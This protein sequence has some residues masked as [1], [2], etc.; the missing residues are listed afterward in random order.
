MRYVINFNRTVNQLLPYYLNGRKLILFL[1][2]CV[3][4]LQDINDSFVK[5]AKDTRIEASMTSQIFKLEWFLKYKFGHYLADPTQNFSIKNGETIGTPIQNQSAEGVP[6]SEQLLMY[7]QS[8]IGA[9]TAKLFYH[10]EITENSPYSFVVFCPALWKDESSGLL[11]DGI[12]EKEF[13]AMLTY[14][15]D[16]YRISG[17]TYKI[18]I[19]Q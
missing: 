19:T 7:K 4:P 8:E 16:K 17:K 14:Y 6:D 10:N 3:K 11:K 1:Q 5:W 15:V 12:S 13:I 18:T 2:S 9:N